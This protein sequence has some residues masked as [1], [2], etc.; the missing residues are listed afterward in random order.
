MH[1]SFLFRQF[2]FE[3]IFEFRLYIS[4]ERIIWKWREIYS[5]VLSSISRED[6]RKPLFSGTFARIRLYL[7]SASIPNKLDAQA[8]YWKIHY[9]S[10]KG[11]GTVEY[12][13]QRVYEMNKKFGSDC[14]MCQGRMNLAIIMDGSGSIGA[15]DYRYAKQTAGQLIDTFSN[16]LLVDIGYVLF[17]KVAEVIFQLKSN[18]TRGQMKKKI[19]DSRYPD[20]STATH[21]GIDEGVRI[22]GKAHNNT[23]EWMADN[24]SLS[25][26]S[27]MLSFVIH[28]I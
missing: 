4:K 22:L 24:L 18:L 25:F 10:L 21:L 23:G 3:F 13:V 11:N 15:G 12:F 1:E 5:H 8:Q 14:N 16:E 28:I 6:L 19:N 7:V 27:H 26:N 17:S 2:S 20:S 9:N